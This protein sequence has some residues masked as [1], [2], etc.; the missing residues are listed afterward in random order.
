M[1]SKSKKTKAI[2]KNKI[3]ENKPNLKADRKRIENNQEILRGLA[4]KENS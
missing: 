3:K 2:R 1:S 4:A